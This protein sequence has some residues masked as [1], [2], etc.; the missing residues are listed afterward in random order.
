MPIVKATKRQA[1]ALMFDRAV[2][3][4]APAINELRSAGVR[5]IRGLMRR[6][7]GAAMR[8][9]TRGPFNYSSTR[10]VLR[11]IQEL[12]LGPG[13]RTI[14][15]A[16]SQRPPRPYTFRPARTGSKFTLRR[17]QQECEARSRA[18]DLAEQNGE[19]SAPDTDR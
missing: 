19:S 2:K 18:S 9:P 12:H 17:L 7:N 10:R 4:L 5:D 16:A 1:R 11:R 14:S 15:T 13:P 3:A 8:A 6:L